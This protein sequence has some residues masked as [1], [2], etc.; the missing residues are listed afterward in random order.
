[1]KEIYEFRIVEKFSHL[2][3]DETEGN[4]LS[5]LIRLVIIEK[6][7][8]KFDKIGEIDKQLNEQN[9]KSFF[10]GWEI[11]RTYSENEIQTAML[12]HLIPLRHILHSEEEFGTEYG[13]EGMCEVCGAG[14][15]R[16]GGFFFDVNKLKRNRHVMMSLSKQEFIVTECFKDICTGYSLNGIT[17]EPVRHIRE[18]KDLTKEKYY[19]MKAKA[20]KL[21][22]SRNTI[23]GVH[24]FDL[25]ESDKTE[26][27]KCPKG[28]KIG[29]S[30]LSELHIKELP[31]IKTY[32]FFKTKQFVSIKRGL[33]KPTQLFLCSARFREM[34]VKE[35]IKDFR[36]EIAHI[37]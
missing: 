28:D 29:L 24:P 35:K 27:Y 33:L 10:Y 14:E 17:F 3:F 12:F 2:L 36:V 37:E 25:S 32:D 16:I 8:P 31:D 26:I 11:R 34:L 13:T 20:P 21:E 22:L 18:K 1:M 4:K 6:E 9:K 5:S 7:N 15:T 30:L 19:V 23:A